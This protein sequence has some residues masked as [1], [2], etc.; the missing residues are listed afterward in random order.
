MACLALPPSGVSHPVDQLI[1]ALCTERCSLADT[2]DGPD[3]KLQPLTTE[4]DLKSIL[5]GL[6]GVLDASKAVA[7]C[8]QWLRRR[9]FV[10]CRVDGGRYNG[11]YHMSVVHPSL[12]QAGLHMPDERWCRIQEMVIEELAKKK[13]AKEAE[14]AEAAEATVPPE[15]VPVPVP[16]SETASVH[17]PAVGSL[18]DPDSPAIQ[19]LMLRSQLAASQAKLRAARKRENYWRQE[20]QTLRAKASALNP[21]AGSTLVDLAVRR[22]LSHC[23]AQGT[24]STLGLDVHRS[25][26]IRWEM[27]VAA[28]IVAESRLFHK[29]CSERVSEASWSVAVH[30]FKGDATNSGVLQQSKLQ[31]FELASCYL[32]DDPDSPLHDM[33]AHAGDVSSLPGWQGHKIWGDIQK[34]QDQ[35]G[36]G[37]EG[38]AEKQLQSC[39]CKHW[40][41]SSAS[42]QQPPLQNL[43][44]WIYVSDAGPDQVKA[45]QLAQLAAMGSRGTDFFFKQL[46][47]LHQSQ[48]IVKLT[49]VAVDYAIKHLD[50]A[51]S[52]KYAAGVCK[53]LHLWRSTNNPSIVFQ[54]WSELYG[55][56]AAMKYASKVPPKPIMGRW[57]SMDNCEATRLAKTKGCD[58][59][60]KFKLSSF[61]A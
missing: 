28:A 46:C 30:S 34:V 61:Q 19:V 56:A 35:T 37:T 53:L 27:K 33:Y 6:H 50:I 12:L 51:F 47:W 16:A 2:G 13:E 38:M 18:S 59:V 52:G 55:D 5:L 22:N 43:R 3:G 23:A 15:P 11:C 17:A 60:F 57:H 39:G 4:A 48:L 40:G 1:V 31:A 25:T 10:A 21:S 32:L 7:S 58:L 49:L 36:L 54:K 8:K 42:Q 20:C 24:A 14:A 29:G 41:A 44:A 9:P 45:S 26:V